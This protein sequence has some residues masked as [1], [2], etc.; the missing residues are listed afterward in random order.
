MRG[1]PTWRRRRRSV[2]A[3]SVR[4]AWPL[5]WRPHLWDVDIASRRTLEDPIETR[6]HPLRVVA[7]VIAISAIVFAGE[8]F[9]RLP[10]CLDLARR[11]SSA[12]RSRF[13]FFSPF[14]KESMTDFC[15]SADWRRVS[16]S[17]SSSFTRGLEDRTSIRPC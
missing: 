12:W 5:L 16:R 6:R 17:T 10:L 14:F 1:G 15:F 3:G 4:S 11:A 8:F 7:V 2:S 9:L 13:F